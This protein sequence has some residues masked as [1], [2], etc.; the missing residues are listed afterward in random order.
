SDQWT[1][2]T[3]LAKRFPSAPDLLA[4][5]EKSLSK[6]QVDLN[7][8]VK[9]AVGAEVDVVFV[10]FAHGGNDVVVLTQPRDKA[11]LDALLAKGSN[12]P[13]RADIDGWTVLADSQAK[14]ESFRKARTAG[15]LSNDREFQDTMRKL[16]QDTLARVYVAGVPVQSALDTAVTRQGAPPGTTRD[17]GTLSALALSATAEDNGVLLDGRVDATLTNEPDSYK[18]QLQ[19]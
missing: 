18:A 17:F 15:S 8:D 10:D 12:P 7:R 9:P 14:I 5:L 4:Q 13:A 6:E 16:P 2:A 19:S 1:K 11:K 3:A